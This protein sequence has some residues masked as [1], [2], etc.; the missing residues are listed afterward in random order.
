MPSSAHTSPALATSGANFS[1]APVHSSAQSSLASTPS[2]A[3]SSPAPVPSGTHSSSA[4]APSGARSSPA[5]VPTGAS[6]SSAPVLPAA[7]QSS[8]SAPLSSNSA[9]PSV[10]AGAY[11]SS[12]PVSLG[13]YS[14]ATAPLQA[15]SSSGAGGTAHSICY[16]PSASTAVSTSA[17]ARLV[18]TSTQQTASAMS[19]STGFGTQA[20]PT[21]I[22]R[23]HRTA[24]FHN[25]YTPTIFGGQGSSPGGPTVF[26][27]TSVPN[28][29]SNGS[30]SHSRNKKHA[31]QDVLK[32]AGNPTKFADATKEVRFVDQVPEEDPLAESPREIAR[33]VDQGT[34]VSKVTKTAR[35]TAQDL[36]SNLW[37]PRQI[38]SIPHLVLERNSSKNWTKCVR[39]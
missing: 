12:S 6:S 36:E 11:C 21:S 26:G 16:I 28:L 39:P 24:Y 8:A 15:S 25:S 3:H 22:M 9:T 32:S 20:G 1:P 31:V 13:S 4:S 10:I 27:P 35:E 14:P 2:G 30:T 23:S 17:P 34:V 7:H 33:T 38:M 5:S 19:F 29:Q 18:L 37:Y